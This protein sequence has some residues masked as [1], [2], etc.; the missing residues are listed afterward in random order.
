MCS[1]ANC[2][3]THNIISSMAPHEFNVILRTT[4]DEFNVLPRTNGGFH[5]NHHLVNWSCFKNDRTSLSSNDP[6][7]VPLFT[8]SIINSY[9]FQ[10][11]L[12]LLDYTFLSIWF[13][14]IY[15]H[16]LQFLFIQFLWFVPQMQTWIFL[17]WQSLLG[18]HSQVSGLCPGVISTVIYIVHYSTTTHFWCQ[19]L[20]N[21]QSAQKPMKYF[22]SLPFELVN[23]SFQLF[24]FQMHDAIIDIIFDITNKYARGWNTKETQSLNMVLVFIN[25]ANWDSIHEQMTI[26]CEIRI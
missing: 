10:F 1:G 26:W 18:P 2:S 21:Y 19:F 14:T 8:K 3:N 4:M 22:V 16:P 6:S 24:I 17:F 13:T 23:I 20:W 5:W 15:H 12:I 7:L 11:M 9:H 25:A